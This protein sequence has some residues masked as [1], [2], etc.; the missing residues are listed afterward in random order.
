M[1]IKNIIIFS[2]IAMVC[3]FMYALSIDFNGCGKGLE[4]YSRL[5][6]S[7]KISPLF[8]TFL[9]LLL[10]VIPFVFLKNNFFKT[11][12]KLIIPVFALL[13]IVLIFTNDQSESGFG[14]STDVP[15]KNLI[16]FAAP[17]IV[18]IS[19]LIALWGFL[20]NEK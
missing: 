1:N 7:T 18:L 16:Y 12:R 15:K 11:W 20:K 10:S 2:V 9:A 17:L 14:Y 13:F 8:N 4:C 19:W 5:L 6:S 3:V